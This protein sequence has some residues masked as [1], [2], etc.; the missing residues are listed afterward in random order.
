MGCCKSPSISMASLER[1]C[2][3]SP[4]A[5]KPLK[6]CKQAWGRQNRCVTF[7]CQEGST[8]TYKQPLAGSHTCV[9]VKCLFYA[10]QTSNRHFIW[11][12]GSSSIPASLPFSFH[13]LITCF[14]MCHPWVFFLFFVWDNHVFSYS[15]T[16]RLCTG[17]SPLIFHTGEQHQSDCRFADNSASCREQ[18]RARPSFVLIPE[19][20]P[21]LTFQRLAFTDPL[22]C[23]RVETH[24]ARCVWSV[25]KQENYWDC[26]WGTWQQIPLRRLACA[27]VS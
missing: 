11:P 16:A 6:A 19:S 4:A 24:A 12:Q 9:E 17:S 15:N 5:I 18:L 8:L 2:F 20:W 21:L 13:C 3:N 1:V 10:D 14:F 27:S 25:L 22:L 7:G 26:D 23:L